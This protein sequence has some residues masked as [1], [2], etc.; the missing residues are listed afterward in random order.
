[1]LSLYNHVP[2]GFTKPLATL[3]VCPEHSVCVAVLESVVVACMVEKN[4]VWHKSARFRA[5]FKSMRGAT[6]YLQLR[7]G[8]MSCYR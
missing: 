8:S 3:V 1:M 6:K 5:I 4:V 7:E 2:G